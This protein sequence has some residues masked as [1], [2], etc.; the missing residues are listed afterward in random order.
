MKKIKRISKRGKNYVQFTNGILIYL[1]K[2]YV[3]AE[4]VTIDGILLAPLKE[5]N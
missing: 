5:N 1:P 4:K 2:E 3:F